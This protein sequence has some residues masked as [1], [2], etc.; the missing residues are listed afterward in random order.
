[1]SRVFGTDVEDIEAAAWCTG[2]LNLGVDCGEIINSIGPVPKSGCSHLDVAFTFLSKTVARSLMV[3]SP[4][5][6]TT[7][8]VPGALDANNASKGKL[9]VKQMR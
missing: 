1:M 9:V 6:V 2:G 8:R 7:N 4:G 5:R 3:G